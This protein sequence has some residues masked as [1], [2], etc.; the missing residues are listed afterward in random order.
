MWL[1]ITPCIDDVRH[2]LGHGE[3]AVSNGRRQAT[4]LGRGEVCVDGV[5]DA[6]AL[7]VQHAFV[8]ANGE[9]NLY[10]GGDEGDGN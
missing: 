6:G 3:R 8:V 10:P 9:A 5:P 1:A 4:S 2:T 7:R